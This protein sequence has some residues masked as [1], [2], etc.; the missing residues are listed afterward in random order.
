MHL[1]WKRVL[2][3]LSIIVGVALIVF[4][5]YGKGQIRAAKGEISSA[6][7]KVEQGNQLFSL[8]PISKQIGQGMSS[9]IQKK[10]AAG[11]RTVEQ[12]EMI[13]MWCQ[14][15]GIVLIVLGAG[16]ILFGGR[17]SKRAR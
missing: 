15:G 8:N 7:K 11:E 6:K 17:R 14:I 5:I 16:L 2:G 1:S 3:L 10:I 9:G 4:V 12:Y 13:F